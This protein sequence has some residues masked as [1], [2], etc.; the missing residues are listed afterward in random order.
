[1]RKLLTR[2]SP[3]EWS[4]AVLA[5]TVGLGFMILRGWVLPAYDEWTALRTMVE[6]QQA[7]HLKLLRNLS[8]KDEVDARFASL[9]ERVWQAES[10]QVTLSSFLREVEAAA[11]QPNLTLIN[12]KPL[13]IRREASVVIYP[14]RLSVAGKPQALVGFV[15]AVLGGE[16]VTGLES[17]SIRGVQGGQTVECTL[18]IWMV[19]LEEQPPSH[20]AVPSQVV[21]GGVVR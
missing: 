15:D 7:Q 17:F 5:V 2:L 19:C 9:D 3:R 18:N 14:V 6:A 13:V 11:R 20:V 8:V 21:Q 10:D 1:M 4:L 16:S 12:M